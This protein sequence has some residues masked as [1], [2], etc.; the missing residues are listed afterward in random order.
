MDHLFLI[1]A[2][3]LAILAA[4]PVG[5]A[6]WFSWSWVCFLASILFPFAASNWR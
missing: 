2:F 4:I 1:I 6:N 3:I 5:G